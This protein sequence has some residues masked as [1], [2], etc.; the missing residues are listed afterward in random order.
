[1]KQRMISMLP[2]FLMLVV[3]STLAIGTTNAQSSE[4]VSIV[5]LATPSPDG[6]EARQ[7]YVAAL[8]PLTKAAGFNIVT[9]LLIQENVVGESGFA[10]TAV[11]EAESA[12]AARAFFSSDAYQAIVPFRDKGFSKFF[13]MIGKDAQ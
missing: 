10:L 2:G 13:V 7:K 9:N 5:V 6:G 1:M 3:A 8:G 12:E 4:S 11:A